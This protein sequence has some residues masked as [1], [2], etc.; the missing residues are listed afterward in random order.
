MKKADGQLLHNQAPETEETVPGESADYIHTHN[1]VAYRH[2]EHGLSF[3]VL[4]ISHTQ[5]L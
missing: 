2:K 4:K 5:K 1:A 3:Q